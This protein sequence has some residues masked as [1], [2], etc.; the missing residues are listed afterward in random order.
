MKVPHLT[1]NCPPPVPIL[2]QLHPVPTTPSNFLKIH[3]NPLN[4]ELNPICHLL[5]LLGAHP[6]LHVSRIRV[7]IILPSMSWSPQWPLSLRLLFTCSKPHFYVAAV[8]YLPFVLHV[9]LY[10]ASEIHFALLH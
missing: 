10:F 3:L 7:N 6:I 4:A 1:H 9:M 8:L 2:S 5:A